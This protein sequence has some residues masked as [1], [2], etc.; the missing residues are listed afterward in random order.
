[1]QAKEISESLHYA[2]IPA[3]PKD[4]L[5]NNKDFKPSLLAMLQ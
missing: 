4:L 5:A 1:M 2:G 3:E